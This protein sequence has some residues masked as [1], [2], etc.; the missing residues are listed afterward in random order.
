MNRMRFL[1][2]M[3]LMAAR[4]SGQD[5]VT[6]DAMT[7]EQIVDR[8]LMSR[9][10]QNKE[11]LKGSFTKGRTSVPFTITL[12]K[13][14]ISF[15][16]DKPKQVVSLNI[17]EKGARLTETVAGGKEQAIATARY[18]EGVRGTDLTYDDLS[19]RFL[20]WPKKSKV[21]TDT[22]QTRKCDVVDLFNPDALGEYYMVRVF[23]D[24]DSGG[25][26]RMMGFDREG[27]LV[28]TCTVTSGMK[29]KSGATVLKSMEILRHQ[30]GSKKVISETTLELRKP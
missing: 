6:P 12:V 21:G 27:K 29:L 19:Q 8:V 2:V 15:G 30:P 24:R 7:A 28:K 5:E 10:M 20:Y 17:T 18:T 9:A 23:A 13:D 1:A 22:V 14:Q 16:F 3:A 26:L 4:V 11:E 25:M